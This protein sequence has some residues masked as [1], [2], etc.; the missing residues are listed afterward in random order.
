MTSAKQI[1]HD[2]FDWVLPLI[3]KREIKNPAK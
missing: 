2:T 1:L 3:P